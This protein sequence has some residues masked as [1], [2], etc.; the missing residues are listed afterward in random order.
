MQK[1]QPLLLKVTPTTSLFCEHFVPQMAET[2]SHINFVAGIIAIVLD[3]IIASRCT[4]VYI[5]F[6]QRWNFV[7]L[8]K[9]PKRQNHVLGSICGPSNKN[10]AGDKEE[11]K[12]LA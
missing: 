8:P 4:P 2:H 3:E 1:Q 12:K 11:W 10:L 6:C 5:S 9:R 7:F